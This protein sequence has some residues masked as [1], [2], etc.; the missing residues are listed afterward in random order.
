MLLKNISILSFLLISS[1]LAACSTTSNIPVVKL[2]RKPANALKKHNA[3]YVSPS[4][5]GSGPNVQQA[6]A[7]IVCENANMRSRA[8]DNNAKNDTARVLILEEYDTSGS[9]VIG[10]VEVNCRNYFDDKAAGR[11]A[12]TYNAGYNAGYSAPRVTST[13]QTSTAST[14]SYTAPT[15]SYTAPAPLPAVQT[16]PIIQS[17]P[18]VISQPQPAPVRLQSASTPRRATF[19]NQTS[20]QIGSFYSVRSGDTLYRIAVNHCTTVEDLSV[21]NNIADPSQIEVNDQLRLP[22]RGC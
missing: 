3:S 13:S 17:T 2:E 19:Q 8:Q 9:Q 11:L 22:A 12:T 5:I 20:R 15:Q 21:I 14:Q 16:T 10:D 7:A 6:E 1:G 18:R 4:P